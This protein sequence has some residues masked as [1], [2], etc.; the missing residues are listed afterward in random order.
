MKKTVVIVLVVV[1]ILS[2]SAC[3]GKEEYQKGYDDGY[4]QAMEDIANETPRVSAGT[5][6]SEKVESTDVIKPAFTTIDVG[7]ISKASTEDGSFTIAIQGA[8][9]VTKAEAHYV[10]EDIPEGYRL[11]SLRCDVENI[12]YSGLYDNQLSRY[13]LITNKL[14]RL[15]DEDGFDCESYD[16]TPFQ[17]GGGYAVTEIAKG[18]KNRLSMPFKVPS[19]TSTVTVIIGGTTQ[20]EVPID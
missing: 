5:A 11:V 4:K 18:A 7:E 10:E 2:L 17:D 14:V 3:G 12:D 9:L 16:Y 6:T 13:D 20:I 8:H 1:M 19:S 15:V